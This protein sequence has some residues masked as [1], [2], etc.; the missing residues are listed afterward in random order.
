M[1]FLVKTQVHHF[2]FVISLFQYSAKH[3]VVGRSVS[4]CCVHSFIECSSFQI[5]KS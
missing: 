5:R 4:F 1:I 3:F 2:L